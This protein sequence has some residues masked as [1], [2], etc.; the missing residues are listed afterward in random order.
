MEGIDICRKIDK[1]VVYEYPYTS[2]PQ[3]E[4]HIHPKFAIF[5]AGS[6]LQKLFNEDSDS[7]PVYEKIL[8][9]YPSVSKI[10]RLYFAWIRPLPT[11]ALEDKTY[12]DSTSFEEFY[13]TPEVNS[14]IANDSDYED[15][16]MW[17]RTRGDG[18][19]LRRRTRSVAAAEQALRAKRLRPRKQTIA[20][21]VGEGQSAQGGQT[22]KQ[23]AP[24]K[25]RKVLSESFTYNRQLL[26]EATLSRINQQFGEAAWTAQ[27]I[28]QWSSFPNNRRVV[29][30]RSVRVPSHPVP[31]H[32]ACGS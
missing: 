15:R 18:I 32:L 5:D 24:V 6:K 7:N 22:R 4:S 16:S 12:V 9:D 27:R 31:R 11:N 13:D 17:N 20:N 1:T 10:R 28:R 29:P 30:S 21:G 3:L 14:D 23:K 19:F 25:K 26:S 2:F 8:K